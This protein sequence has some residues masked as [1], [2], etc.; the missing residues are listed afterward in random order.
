[1]RENIVLSDH[2]IFTFPIYTRISLFINPAML[3]H[4]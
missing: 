2:V 1:M 4:H 3:L